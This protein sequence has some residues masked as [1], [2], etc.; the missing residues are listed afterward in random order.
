MKQWLQ[1]LAGIGAA[2]LAGILILVAQR[3]GGGNQLADM[4]A[5]LGIVAVLV[6]GAVFARRYLLRDEDPT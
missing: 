3:M 5:I 4:Q 2:V 1:V 6:L